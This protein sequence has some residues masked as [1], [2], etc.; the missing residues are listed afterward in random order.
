MELW[1]LPLAIGVWIMIGIE[2]LPRRKKKMRITIEIEDELSC[3]AILRNLARWYELHE[4]DRV[5][6][7]LKGVVTYH[8]GTVICKR[9]Y[10]KTDCFIALR[11]S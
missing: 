5:T 4:Q 3:S 11:D 7:P 10:R 6:T 9:D 8:D 1:M 2:L